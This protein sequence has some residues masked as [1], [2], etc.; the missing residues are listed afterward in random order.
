M[1]GFRYINEQAIIYH[2]AGMFKEDRSYDV[3]RVNPIYFKRQPKT[4]FG[5]GGNFPKSPGHYM[6]CQMLLF[7]LLT[8][9]IATTAFVKRLSIISKAGN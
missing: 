1:L 2:L 6:V 9:L 5:A 7:T 3:I 4:F 8:I